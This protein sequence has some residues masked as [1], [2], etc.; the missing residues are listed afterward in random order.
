MN[1]NLIHNI[2]NVVIAATAAVTAFLLAT[3]CIQHP[4][5]NLSCEGS[6]ISPTWTT[7]IVAGLGVLKSVINIARDG[8]T[9]LFKTQPPVR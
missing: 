8:F 2:L 3:G 6:W 1:T 7:G 5:G 9:G 4:S